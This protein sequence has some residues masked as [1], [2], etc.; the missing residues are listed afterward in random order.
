MRRKTI[1]ILC[2]RVKESC[3]KFRYWNCLYLW[4]WIISVGLNRTYMVFAFCSLFFNFF[5]SLYFLLFSTSV[6]PVHYFRDLQ[7][8]FLVI[9]SLKMDLMVLF[10]HLK[11]ILLPYFSV[12]SFSFQFSAVFKRTLNPC[13]SM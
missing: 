5:S 8:Y 1:I 10:T 3:R 6:G 13:K 4:G 9:F 12:F 7:T 11:I 2:W